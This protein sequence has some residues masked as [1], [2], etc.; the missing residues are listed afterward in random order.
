LAIARATVGA[1][2]AAAIV[3]LGAVVLQ[4]TKRARSFT[5]YGLVLAGAITVG[6]AFGELDIV[7]KTG[8]KLDLDGLED[9]LT[10]PFCLAAALLAAPRC[11]SASVERRVRLGCRRRHAPARASPPSA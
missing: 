5:V 3:G 6:G 7:W 11:C 9:L 8:D 10:V 1:A 4:V 2:I